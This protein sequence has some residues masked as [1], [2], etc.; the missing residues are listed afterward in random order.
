MA[1]ALFLK[2]SQATH[3]LGYLLG[4]SLTAGS[5]IL[6]S[7]N[8]GAGKTT[9]VQGIAKGLNISESIVSPT[10]T[11]I[12]EYTDGRLP[13]Y[14]LDLY[15]LKPNEVDSIYPDMYW[16]GIEV[17]PGI[18]AIEWQ[19]RLLYKPS[20]YL[21]LNLTIEP[22][23]GRTAS[24]DIVGNCLLDLDKLKNELEREKFKD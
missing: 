1:C 7:G 17:M 21:Q 4:K 22:R 2:N 23:E 5:V 8:L 12:G 24:L 20:S 6:L 18:T 9:L 15:R 10:F 19:E 14:H 13:L 3:Q 16:E 11:L